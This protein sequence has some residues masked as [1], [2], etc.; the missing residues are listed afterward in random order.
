VLLPEGLASKLDPDSIK[1]RN[2]DM[3]EDQGRPGT[4]GHE[5]ED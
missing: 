3:A 1:S 2:K 4:G 5:E